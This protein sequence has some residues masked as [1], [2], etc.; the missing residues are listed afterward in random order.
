MEQLA[1]RLVDPA[2]RRR[3]PGEEEETGRGGSFLRGA[4][5]EEQ[6]VVDLA[7]FVQEADAPCRIVEVAVLQHE[8]FFAIDRRDTAVDAE[9]VPPGHGSI[10]LA[11]AVVAGGA[12]AL[13]ARKALAE[14]ERTV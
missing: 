11:D 1:L 13:F 2:E 10:S 4:G 9:P 14:P 8:R 5:A 7:D 6:P 12:V 3:R